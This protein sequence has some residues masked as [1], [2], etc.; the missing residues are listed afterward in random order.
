[1]TVEQLVKELSNAPPTST[2]RLVLETPQV[3]GELFHEAKVVWWD[4]LRD[5]TFIGDV[6]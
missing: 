3:E 2:V 4:D 6:L 1:M 5:T